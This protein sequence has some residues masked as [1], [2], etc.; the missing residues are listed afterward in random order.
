MISTKMSL[1]GLQAVRWYISCSGRQ[2]IQEDI[3][4]G[5]AGAEAGMIPRNESPGLLHPDGNRLEDLK[6]LFSQANLSCLPFTFTS[7]IVS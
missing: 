4:Q 5:V 6:L 7:S 2:H 1:R 3:V